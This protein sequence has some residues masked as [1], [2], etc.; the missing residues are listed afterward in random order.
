MVEWRIN[1]YHILTFHA[2]LTHHQ[3]PCVC[4]ILPK[5]CRVA[6]SPFGHA[7]SP[8][9]HVASL[10]PPGREFSLIPPGCLT[11]GILSSQYS[12]LFGCLTSGFLLRRHSTRVSHIRNYSSPTFH[13]GISHPDFFSA[14]V[15]PGYLTFRI[16]LRR[17][18]T[19]V[20]HIRNSSPPTFHSGISHPDFFS[21]DIPPGHLTSGIL[22]HRHSM[23]ISHIRNSVHHS[24]LIQD[25][26]GFGGGPT[27]VILLLIDWLIDWFDCYMWLICTIL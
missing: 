20:S 3:Y 7:D 26:L 27:Y 23:R 15:P 5:N 19:R 11:S 22:L 17:H 9:R 13:P 21:A 14:D 4:G 18:S 24:S 25:R 16:L 1:H 8:L 6:P 2:R 12:T 10:I